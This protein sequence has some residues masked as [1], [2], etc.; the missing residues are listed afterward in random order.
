M[1]GIACAL[2]K[3]CRREKSE[4]IVKKMNQEQEAYENIYENENKKNNK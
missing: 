1:D 3:K 4:E 2:S